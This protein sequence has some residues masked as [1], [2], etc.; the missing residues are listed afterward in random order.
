MLQLVTDLAF[1]AIIITT[2]QL[3]APALDA[4]CMFLRRYCYPNHLIDCMQLFGQPP[5]EVSRFANSI[6]HH[7]YGTFHHLLDTLNHARLTPDVLEGFAKAV[8]NKG[9]ALSDT[10]GFLDRTIRPIARPIVI[11]EGF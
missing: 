7:L 11:V 4:F 3:R 9:A 1:P 5:C 2:N 8:S 10:W 6:L